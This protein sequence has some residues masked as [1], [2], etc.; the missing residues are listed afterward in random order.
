MSHLT[1]NQKWN[2]RRW[3]E[4][5]KDRVRELNRRWRRE[6]LEKSRMQSRERMRKHRARKKAAGGATH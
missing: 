4:A 1:L 6:N 2:R 5:N 3:Y